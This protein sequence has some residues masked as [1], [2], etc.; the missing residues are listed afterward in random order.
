MGI[1]EVMQINRELRRI[2]TNSN[3]AQE[4]E[5]IAVACGMKTLHRGG[6]DAII[7]GETSISEY[8]RVL[9]AVTD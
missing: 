3:V 4:I 7:T 8:I 1:Y 9:G 2:I 6:L 5:E